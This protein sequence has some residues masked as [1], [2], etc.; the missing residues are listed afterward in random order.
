ML[1]KEVVLK[2]ASLGKLELADGEVEDYAKTLTVIFEHFE[3]L[4]KIDTSNVEPMITP[5]P[6]ESIPRQDIVEGSL[7][8]DRAL[9]NAPARQGNLFKVPPVVG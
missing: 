5:S 8:A 9:V 7:G 3:K 1:T 2:I 4:G 6:I